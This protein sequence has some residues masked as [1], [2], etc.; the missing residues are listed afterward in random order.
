VT[1]ARFEHCARALVLEIQRLAC[2]VVPKIDD[3]VPAAIDEDFVAQK[4]VRLRESV[5]IGAFEEGPAIRDIEEFDFGL[6]SVEREKVSSDQLGLLLEEFNLEL[7]ARKDRVHRKKQ[8]TGLCADLEF[9]R[10]LA[11][12]TL[13]QHHCVKESDGG[14]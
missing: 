5:C 13:N 14:C 11:R 10:V 7:V 2:P 4:K 6:L 9:D 3:V 12:G 1:E 8:Q